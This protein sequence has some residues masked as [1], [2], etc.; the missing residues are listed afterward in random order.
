VGIWQ[1]EFI[2]SFLAA[3]GDGLER[4]LVLSRRKSL[5]I[6]LIAV[7]SE[8]SILRTEHTDTQTHTADI[9]SFFIFFASGMIPDEK[10]VFLLWDGEKT[11][12][13]TQGMDM[14]DYGF[15]PGKAAIAGNKES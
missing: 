9:R 1:L 14:G 5:F 15:F 6:D 2:D 8:E 12:G 7:D 11:G 10:M 3:F 4:S 13:G